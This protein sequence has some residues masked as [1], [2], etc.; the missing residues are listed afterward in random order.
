MF[1]R[2]SGPVKLPPIEQALLE[3]AEII[4]YLGQPCPEQF[5]DGNTNPLAVFRS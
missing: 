1:P 5:A 4:S 3:E 2:K